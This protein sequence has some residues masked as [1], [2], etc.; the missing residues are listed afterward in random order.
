MSLQLQHPRPG[1]ARLTLDRP[2]KRNAF[3]D[4]LIAELLSAFE[5]FA[6]DPQLRVIELAAAGKHFSAGADL[7]WMK[8]QGQQS[9]ADNHAGALQLAT[10]LQQIDT[11]PQVVVARVQGAAFGGALGLVGAAHLVIAA[12]DARF[13]LSEVRLGLLPAVIA[14]YVVRA[15]GPR[16]SRRWMSSAEVMDAATA[17]RLGL[18]HEVVTPVQ[19]DATVAR[20]IDNLLL[21][22]PAAQAAIPALIAAVNRTPID[23]AMIDDTCQRIAARRRSVEGQEGMAAFLEKR[24][25]A[26]INRS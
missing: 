23:A 8:K 17:L 3:D 5:T 14:P 25:P 24:P 11:Q 18:V 22:A 15:I 19:L 2:E 16:Q 10:L 6:T 21:A 9:E 4:R 1:V 26:W 20:I 7:G 13:C 12:D